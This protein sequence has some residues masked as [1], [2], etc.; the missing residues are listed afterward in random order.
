MAVNFCNKEQIEFLLLLVR[1]HDDKNCSFRNIR[2]MF[3]KQIALEEKYTHRDATVLNT[4][5]RDYIRWKK[6][7]QTIKN[8]LST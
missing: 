8:D 5:R 4:V 7:T 2:S 6:T 3:T 1:L